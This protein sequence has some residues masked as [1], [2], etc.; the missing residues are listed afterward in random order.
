MT[1][2]S[3]SMTQVR[4]SEPNEVPGV[5]ADIST[6]SLVQVGSR[7]G[8]VSWIGTTVVYCLPLVSVPE[9]LPLALMVNVLICLLETSVQELGVGEVDRLADPGG[10]EHEEEQQEQHERPQPEP[11]A[12]LWAAAAGP[13]GQACRLRAEATRAW[14]CQVPVLSSWADERGWAATPSWVA[15]SWPK[16]R[17]VTH[18]A[19]SR[20]YLIVNRDGRWVSTQSMARAT[21][22][23][24]AA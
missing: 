20:S 18:L 1:N 5:L 14:S 16:I 24:H 7:V 6:F 10:G 8:L 9:A 21:A 2:G 12:P 22:F 3:S 11:V 17:S 4:T 19:S 15:P 23:L 13:S